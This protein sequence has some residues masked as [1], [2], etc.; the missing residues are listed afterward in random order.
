MDGVL[1]LVWEVVLQWDSS[2][3]IGCLREGMGL[4]YENE[5]TQRCSIP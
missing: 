3:M 4:L 1:L 5:K 2:S